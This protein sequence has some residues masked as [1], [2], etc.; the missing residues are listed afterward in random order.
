MR[1]GKPLRFLTL[2]VGGWA[3]LR[4][5]T[6]WPES[7]PP[8]SESM[9]GATSPI[10]RVVAEASSVTVGAVPFAVARPAP[11]LNL[12][13]P[14]STLAMGDAPRAEMVEAETRDDVLSGSGTPQIVEAD[15][16][17]DS[18]DDGATG[19]TLEARATA[20]EHTARSSRLHGDAWMVARPSGGDSLAFGQLGASQA[21]VRLTYAVDRDRRVALS[22]RVA[23]PLSGR[24]REAAAGVDWQPLPLPVHLLAEVRAPLDGGSALPAVQVIGGGAARLPFGL[25]LEGY[26][27][28][29]AVR[30]RGA[31]ADGSARVTRP[32][33]SIGRA[34]V[35][36]G[37]GSW[38]AAQR[39]VSRVDVG[40]TLGVAVPAG[41]AS[42]RL[43][44]DYRQRIVGR[45]RPGSGPAVTL[46][47]SF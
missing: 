39:G 47:S 14:P 10:Q 38:G 13:Y 16:V 5:V 11:T 20:S 3:G 28:A 41:R 12:G 23:A 25:L 21:G 33:A 43:G 9:A 36:L 40:P 2:V 32:L 18:P 34:R 26:A 6:L 42:V 8:P 37:A 7:L 45:A 22:G 44:I 27:Q 15:F 17:G 46:G 1:R 29:G 35:D 4:F 19:Q 31:F 24:G 30:T